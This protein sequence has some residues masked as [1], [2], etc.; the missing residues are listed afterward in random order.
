MLVKELYHD[1][2]LY[3]ESTLAHYINHLLSERKISLE[4]NISQLDLNQADHIKVAEMI[5]KNIL[6]IHPI[7]IYSL[8]KNKHEFVFIFAHSAEEAK[9]FFSRTFYQLPINCHE[10]PLEVEMARG[11][12]GISFREM[13]KEF[14]QFPAVVGVVRR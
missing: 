13:K 8:K 1:C 11:K 2:L 12:S 9:Q 7:R 4:D 14:S 5:E 3:E 6:G 10:Y